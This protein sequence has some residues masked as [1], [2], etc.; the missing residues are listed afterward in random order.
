MEHLY[1]IDYKSI[2]QRIKKVRKAI[3]ITQGQLAEMAHVTT[4]YVSKLE[5]NRTACSLE[6]MTNICNALKTD[7]NLLILGEVEIIE[8]TAVDVLIFNQLAEFTTREKE[9]LLLVL[10]AMK[11]CKCGSN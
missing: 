8:H 4:N 9:A 11:I 7:I 5:T 2:G 1:S 3:G 10:N 6:T